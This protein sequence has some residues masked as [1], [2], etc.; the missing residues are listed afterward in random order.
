LIE[1]Q[2]RLPNQEHIPLCETYANKSIGS[3][4]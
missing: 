1:N 2:T 4:S 3:V